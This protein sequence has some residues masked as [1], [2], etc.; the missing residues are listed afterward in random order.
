MCMHSRSYS[1]LDSGGDVMPR[2]L[3][4]RTRAGATWTEAKYFQFIRSALRKATM[5]YPVKQKVL[6]ANRRPKQLPGRHKWECKC[7]HCNLWWAQTACQVDHIVPAGKLSSYA[8]LPGFVARLFCEPEDMQVL[9]SSCH[10]IKTNEERKS[11]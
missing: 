10:Q 1:V 7:A 3:K 6:A 8:D 2:Q 4:P 5:R 11:K 9:C